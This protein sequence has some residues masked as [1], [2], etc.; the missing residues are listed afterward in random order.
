MDT[1]N[2]VLPEKGR[3]EANP[4]ASYPAGLLAPRGV[5]YMLYESGI[6]DKAE[7]SC[8]L[9]ILFLLQGVQFHLLLSWA[10]YQGNNRKLV[11]RSNILPNQL[12]YTKWTI[13]KATPS[14]D[15]EQDL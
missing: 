2:L 7:L 14:F 4:P 11:F 15:D 10:R 9:L 5:I 8:F 12:K 13:T 6:E 3:T 1:D